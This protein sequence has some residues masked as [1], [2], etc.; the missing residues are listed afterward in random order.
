MS[1]GVIYELPMEGYIRGDKMRKKSF[2]LI[3]LLIVMAVI[4]ALIAAIVPVGVK[5][6]KQAKATT[7]AMNLLDL[8]LT[9][10]EKFYLNHNTSITLNSLKSYFAVE[11]NINDYEIKTTFGA[12]TEHV[13][14]WYKKTDVNASE[15]KRILSSVVATGNNKPMVV[16]T[17]EKYW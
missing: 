16:L 2:T 12:T 1:V 17:V 9:A 4:A 14:I 5:A 7:V 13:Y 3:E 8:S 10:M 6:I 15:V 11:K